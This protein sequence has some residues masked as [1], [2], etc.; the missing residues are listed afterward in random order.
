MRT[1]NINIDW[2]LIAKYH[3]G[4]CSADEIKQ[5]QNWGEQ[6]ERNKQTIKQIQKDLE[7][8]NLNKEMERVNVDLAWEK[9][10]GKI[11]DESLE[12]ELNVSK[13]FN[14]SRILRYAAI[15]IILIGLAFITRM[16]YNNLNS[17]KFLIQAQLDEQGKKTTLPDGSVVILNSNT[18]IEYNNF[19]ALNER[20]V[21]LDGEA[22][23]DVVK[24][25]NKP[26]VIET[27]DAEIRVLGTSFNV[28]TNLPKKRVEVFVKT[29]LVQLSEAGNLDNNILITPGNIGLLNK[30]TLKKQIN[31]DLNKLSWKTKKII[32]NQDKLDIVLLTLN[33]TYNAQIICNDKNIL[34]LRYTSTFNNQSL[35]SILDVICSTLD[36]KI[37]RE[38]NKIELISYTN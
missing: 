3:S 34:N 19:D 5:I 21:F 25:K 12:D 22:F 35:N 24:N 16:V 28:N 18:K 17:N 32:F 33:K 13:K 36:L 14:F 26:F 9:V 31:T 6:D 30:Q 8:I 2:G 20:R 15:L 38:G 29:G 4:E 11:R 7:L 10:R 1:N 27:Q 23:F 37:K